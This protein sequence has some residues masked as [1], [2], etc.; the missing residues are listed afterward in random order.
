MN[1]KVKAGL[2]T[3]GIVAVS[4]G[5]SAVLKSVSEYITPDRLLTGVMVTSCGILLYTMYSIILSK[6]EIDE[7][8]KTKLEEMVDQK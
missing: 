4:V 1:L 7:K 8:Y 3:V 5:A 2:A 6:L